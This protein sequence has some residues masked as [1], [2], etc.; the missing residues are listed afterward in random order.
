MFT[1]RRLQ[2]TIAFTLLLAMLVSATAASAQSTV[3]GSVTIR[4]A[5]GSPPG[6]NDSLVFSLNG[7]GSAGSGF[8]YEAWLVRSDS[9]RMSV[10]TFSGPTSNRTWNSPTQENLAAEFVQMVITREPSPDP[11]PATS[12]PVMFAATFKQG[13]LIPFRALLASSRATATGNGVA[14]AAYGQA[15][16]AQQ[17]GALAQ[18]STTLADQQMHAQHVINVI[19]GLGAPGDGTGL[20]FYANQAKALAQQAKAAAAS[21]DTAIIAAADDAILRADRVIERAGI[22]KSNA[23]AVLDAT[24]ETPD[25][26]LEVYLAN[27]ASMGDGLVSSSQNLIRASQNVGAY[28]FVAGPAPQPP[29]AGDE[30]VAMLALAVLGAGVVLTSGGFLILRRRQTVA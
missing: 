13:V 11:D 24:E 25:I 6:T 21:T 30:M 20:I 17:H 10:G 14:Q 9:S 27:V 29:S 16:I 28:R 7:L 22:A 2:L 19:D 8:R 23:Q 18:D 5:P 1:R 12:G 4:S 3:G 15:T 26:I